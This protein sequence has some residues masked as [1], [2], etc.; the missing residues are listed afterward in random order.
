MMRSIDEINETYSNELIQ[1]MENLFHEL[2]QIHYPYFIVYTGQ[3]QA[4]VT[5]FSILFFYTKQIINIY[6]IF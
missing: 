4:N 1:M 2:I 5:I 3:F 6:K